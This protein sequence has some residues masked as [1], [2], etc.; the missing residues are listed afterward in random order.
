MF[1][2]VF[3]NIDDVLWKEAG[4]ASELDYAEQTSW[5]LCLKYLDD[6]EHERRDK[7]DLTGTRYEFIIAPDYRWSTWA[8]PRL[9]DG[10]PDYN[11]SLKGDDLIDFVNRKLFPYLQGFKQRATGPGHV[12]LSTRPRPQHGKTSALNDDDLT[13]FVALQATF[14]AS[15]KSWSVATAD[16]DAATSDLSVKNPNGKQVSTLRDPSEIL[17]E[18]AALDAE[19]ADILNSI[20]GML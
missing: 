6:L 12:V 9:N 8:A 10:R 1:E 14:G 19:T 16:L 13:E 17:A 4:C 3:K 11:S 7:A 5:M 20:R 2:Q 15:D 18:I